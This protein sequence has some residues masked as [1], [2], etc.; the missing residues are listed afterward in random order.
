MATGIA[1]TNGPVLAERI[2]A[3]ESTLAAWRRAIEAGDEDALAA[4]FEDARR[5]LLD[6]G[7]AE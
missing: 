2:G 6:G 4:R 3:L 7:G 5:R 1:I